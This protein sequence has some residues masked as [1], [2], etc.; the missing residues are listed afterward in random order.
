M[1]YKRI[2]LVV[3]DSVGAGALPD[4]DRF[5]DVGANTIGN[6]SRAT[7]GIS[8]PVL[9]SFGYGNLTAIVGV[10]PTAK[11]RAVVLK[12]S[13]IS[14]G[15]DTMTGHW[16]LMGLKT[17]VP[18]QTFTAHGFPPELIAELE[19]RTG[20]KVIGNKAA[21]GTEILNELG[22]RQMKT[23]ELIVYTSADSVLQ[24]AAHEE[25]I[26]LAELYEICHIAR[27]LT[28]KP[29]WLVGRVIAR[30][31]LGNP[32]DGFRR[33]PN[34]HDYALSP[35]APTILDRLAE[36]KY[37]VISIG[38]IR[39]IFNGS[40][41]T[42]HH[43]IISNHDGMVK[44]T[45]CA[46]QPF[47]GLCFTN[48][49]DFDAMYGHRRDPQG[50]KLALEEFDRDLGAFLPHLHN[51]DLLMITADHGNDPTFAGTD[52]TREYVP[53]I[54]YANELRGDTLPDAETFADVAATVAANFNVAP[55]EYG[56]NLL[57]LIG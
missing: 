36:S 32:A 23:G 29:E 46:D 41:I 11:P 55:T 44:T 42:E 51:N 30:P 52:H 43:G 26:P 24:I 4:A 40:G 37:D 16:E 18:F 47:T 49:V 20:R 22:P 27:E 21:S 13:E 31:Y 15:K 17:A 7:G 1:K 12:M 33:T 25:I 45:A 54:I 28:M 50:Y 56:E 53:L 38:K 57:R 14:S 39:D 3:M 10:P 5:G 34:R 2:F 35:F 9:Q 48:L 8:L 6:L 19:R